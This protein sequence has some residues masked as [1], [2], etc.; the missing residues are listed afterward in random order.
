MSLDY[1]LEPPEP[2]TPIFCHCSYCEEP[3]YHDQHYFE[4]G[5][6]RICECCI[7]EFKK[8]ADCGW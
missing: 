5:F 2:N 7:A 4:I 1:K 6:E 8:Y 3:I